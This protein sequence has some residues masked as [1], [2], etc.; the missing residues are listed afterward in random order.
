VVNPDRALRK[1]AAARAWPILEFRG[2]G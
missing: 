1:I 2:S